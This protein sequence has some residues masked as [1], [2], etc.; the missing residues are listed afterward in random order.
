[1]ENPAHFCMEINN[2]KPKI[3]I[4]QGPVGPF[5][6]ELSMAF[7]K[8]GCIVR[9][10]IFNGGDW[11]YSSGHN[12][13][14]YRKGPNE[15]QTFI[16]KLTS[17]FKPDFAIMFGDERPI[18][19]VAIA[20][21][22]QRGIDYWCFE[23]GYIRPNYVTFERVGNNANSMLCENWADELKNI[24]SFPK[25]S[26]NS[27]SKKIELYLN[28]IS[29][30]FFRN[31]FI[32]FAFEKL[33]K[34]LF[35]NY[36]HHREYK[37]LDFFRDYI[38]WLGYSKF[39]REQAFLIQEQIIKSSL[40]N[41]F[42][43]L[44]QVPEDLQL[45]SHGM[46][47]N[48]ASI[49]E[50]IMISFSCYADHKA[51]LLFKI[52]PLNFK[53]NQDYVLI[54]ELAFRYDLE[55]RV[56]IVCSNRNNIIFKNCA[57]GLTINSTAGLEVLR[58]SKNIFTFGV[59]IYDMFAWPKSMD[60]ISDLNNFWSAARERKVFDWNII[61]NYILNSLIAGDF[62]NKSSF[63]ELIEKIILKLEIDDE[64]IQEKIKKAHEPMISDQS[65]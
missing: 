24:I 30:Y 2:M 21:F 48:N 38:S 3:L 16:D 15:W 23:E 28:G 27:N 9:R 52:H 4:L 40:N 51:K 6:D 46:G 59:A 14:F 34:I 65:N 42:V 33:L 61:E 10:V 1:M 55:D 58:H 5:F 18:H 31:G 17:G 22:K 60:I 41:Y 50:N 57:A 45:L 26:S 39:F 8:N 13:I 49:I 53:I 62:Y 25:L 47:W 54:K 35:P 20:I 36:I 37:I 19:K 44:L 32:Y 11:F 56:H 12:R 63:E 64:N 7:E 29:K 43:V